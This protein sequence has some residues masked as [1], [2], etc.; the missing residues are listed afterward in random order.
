MDTF[1]AVSQKTGYVLLVQIRVPDAVGPDWIRPSASAPPGRE[2]RVGQR[3]SRGCRGGLRSG[4]TGISTSAEGSRGSRWRRGCLLKP[5][6]HGLADVPPDHLPEALPGPGPAADA[7][8]PR[9]VVGE[10]EDSEPRGD[11]QHAGEEVGDAPVTGSPWQMGFG[12]EKKNEEI[13]EA[14]RA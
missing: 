12:G 9:E 6:R 1:L 11:E 10:G 5:R 8:A 13:G 4:R 7:G 3:R 2:R 14:G